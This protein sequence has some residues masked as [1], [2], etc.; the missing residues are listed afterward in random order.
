LLCREPHSGHLEEL[1]ANPFE[2]LL[3]WQF[4]HFRGS[5]HPGNCNAAAW[6]NRTSHSTGSRLAPTGACGLSTL[7]ASLDIE[8]P[9]FQQEV[10]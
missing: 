7:A 10:T 4:G 5:S 9:V 1:R 6:E 2:H 3:V 8:V